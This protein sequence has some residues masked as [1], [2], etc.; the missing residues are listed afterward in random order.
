MLNGGVTTAP[1]IRIG[2]FC[3][4]VPLASFTLRGL[5]LM[6]INVLGKRRL[7][8]DTFSDAGTGVGVAVGV[9]VAVGGPVAAGG[10]FAD[11]DVGRGSRLI[12]LPPFRPRSPPYT[13]PA[14]PSL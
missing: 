3:W 7:L 6:P 14:F 12:C 9:A 5:L 4:L 10:V 11:R 8:G 13:L 2:T 1:S